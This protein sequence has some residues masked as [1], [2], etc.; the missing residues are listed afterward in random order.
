MVPNTKKDEYSLPDILDKA[1]SFHLFLPLSSSLSDWAEWIEA[2]QALADSYDRK[3]NRE[4]Q[5]IK[6]GLAE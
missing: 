3:S 5:D 1:V 2:H 6:T 4:G